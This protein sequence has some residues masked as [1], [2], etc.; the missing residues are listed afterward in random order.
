MCYHDDQNT[1]DPIKDSIEPKL[2][3]VSGEK[4]WDPVISSAFAQ[5]TDIGEIA[6]SSDFTRWPCPSH[7]GTEILLFSTNCTS[8]RM[9]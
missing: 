5:L 7:V 8:G 3:V 2:T 4:S 1:V 9:T 6:R